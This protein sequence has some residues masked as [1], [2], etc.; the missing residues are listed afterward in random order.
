MV[1]VYKAMVLLYDNIQNEIYQMR[2]DANLK[3]EDRNGLDRDGKIR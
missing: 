1:K 2:T 3:K